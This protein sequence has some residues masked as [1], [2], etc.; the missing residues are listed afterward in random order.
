M[1][2]D[3]T[4]GSE[5]AAPPPDEA[6]EAYAQRLHDVLDA[7]DW[8]AAR[9]ICAEIARH[10]WTHPGWMTGKPAKRMLGDLRRKRQFALL[11][12]L[13]E[14]FMMSELGLPIVRRQFAQALIEQGRYA[15]AEAMLRGM[16]DLPK[17]S[18][19]Y[20][21]AR[22]LLGRLY[23]QLYVNAGPD[24]APEQQRFLLRALE[25]YRHAYDQHPNKNYWHGINIVALLARAKRDDVPVTK[26]LEGDGMKATAEAIVALLDARAAKA[27]ANP[28]GKLLLDGEEIYAFEFA[29]RVEAR[30]ALGQF[31]QALLVLS[32]YVSRPD[33]DAFEL[34]STER[35]LREVWLLDP[36]PDPEPVS[37]QLLSILR[38]VLLKKEGGKV[39]LAPGAASG[40]L[41][42]ASEAA[43]RMDLE[44]VLGA[45]RFQTLEWYRQGL[46][47]CGG[48]VRIENTNKRGIGTGWIC[49]GGVFNADWLGRNVIVTNKHVVSPSPEGTDGQPFRPEPGRVALLPEDAVI[50]HELSN[51]RTPAGEV[52]WSSPDLALD[53]TV[54]A[55]PALPAGACVLTVN[56][57][58]IALNA[59]PDRVYV[60]GHP[61]GRGLEFSLQDNVMLDLDASRLHYRAPTEGGSSG[62]PVFDDR[63]RVIALHH[64]GGKNV[65]RLKGGG[66]YDANEGILA[67][68]IS[69]GIT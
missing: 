22:G 47:C 60:L 37:G 31:E 27:T 34:A 13:S 40:E 45:D 43:S 49:D 58:Q 68:A 57:R 29:T 32:E 28:D 20:S 11:E 26:V 39:T 48:I 8:D 36:D 46:E 25:E 41:K 3:V 24:R 18:E 4:E 52:L 67:R 10:V 65:P 35:Q 44:A 64:A 69:G 33:A 53:V 51:T 7:F 54:I 63:W 21:E 30:V 15:G 38:A 42:A 62:S 56:K 17:D 12:R 19:D 59:P 50:F 9:A 55:L 14:V 1:T 16:L 66:R 6:P 61:D 5:T 23:K 2:I